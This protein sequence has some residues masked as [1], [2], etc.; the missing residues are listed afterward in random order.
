MMPMA[1]GSFFVLKRKTIDINP[2]IALILLSLNGL[3]LTKR[4]TIQYEYVVSHLG[5]A[6]LHEHL[7]QLQPLLHLAC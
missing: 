6:I 3:R 7:L 5:L 1:K 4:R 2:S